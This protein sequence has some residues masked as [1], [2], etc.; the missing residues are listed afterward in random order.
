M[1]FIQY[2][3]QQLVLYF[4]K[5]NYPPLYV[6]RIK[7]FLQYASFFNGKD[8]E[9]SFALYEH[10]NFFKISD[11]LDCFRLN[12]AKN[13]SVPLLAA[14][15]TSDQFHFSISQFY[16]RNVSASQYFNFSFD[17]AKVFIADSYLDSLEEIIPT[18]L[19]LRPRNNYEFKLAIPSIETKLSEPYNQCK[20]RSPIGHNYHRRNCIEEC[21]FK[22][23]GA[24][25][26]CTF[27]DGLFSVD[28][29]K[30]CKG[31]RCVI[32]SFVFKSIIKYIT[33]YN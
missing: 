11:H 15:S 1:T 19:V 20:S 17:T 13:A 32:A 21:V 7:D 27:V 8:L 18:Y 22:R 16:V 2:H 29:L 10:I 23:I 3:F 26:N 6:P 14:S 33:N 28:G 30:R 4:L 12:S 24:K 5:R 25:Y 9:N 31:Q